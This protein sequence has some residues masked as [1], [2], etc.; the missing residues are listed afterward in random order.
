MKIE[1]IG[2]IGSGAVGKALAEGF[3]KLGYHVTIGSRDPGKLTDWADK[4]KGSIQT[5]TFENAAQ[6]SDAIVLATRWAGK[7]TRQAIVMAGKKTL[8]VKL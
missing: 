7:A 8:R 2:I 1:R 4:F 3:H 6:Q 5:E